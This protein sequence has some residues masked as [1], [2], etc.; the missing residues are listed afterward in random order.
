MLDLRVNNEN[1]F[2][3]MDQNLK[4]ASIKALKFSTA[5]KLFEVFATLI[6]TMVMAR[7]V[8]P[9]DFGII[10]MCS[11]FTGV[12][13]L[14]VDFGT[15]D[16]IIRQKEKKL[17]SGFLSSIFW[18][19]TLIGILFMLV[20]VLV[21]GWIAELYGYEII[22]PIITVLSITVAF[23]AMAS[24]PTAIVIHGLD[25]KRVFFQKLFSLSVSGFVG[26][27]MAL[28]GY[29]VWSLAAYQFVYVISASL[30]IWYLSS[31]MP[32]LLF[33]A[34]HIKDIF[35]FSYYLS[36]SKIMNYFT[37]KGDL[38]LI[39]K[40][41]DAESLGIYSKGYQITVKI[42]K[43]INDVVIKVMYPSMSKIQDDKDMV[44]N[45]YMSVFQVSLSLY[46]IV[47]L[48]GYMYSAEIV[49]LLLGEQWIDVASLVPVFLLL[50][51][52]LGVASVSSHSL[53]AL[54]YTK[55]MFKIVS[56]CSAL[57]ILS[58]II[59]LQ[60]GIKGVAAG[61]LF[62]VVILF[63]LL[64]KGCLNYLPI[65]VVDIFLIFSRNIVLMFFVWFVTTEV[66]LY[67]DIRLGVVRLVVGAFLILSFTMMYFV[68]LNTQELKVM[69]S[70]VKG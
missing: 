15:S 22:E 13:A 18:L 29:G 57:T 69:R 38:F 37:K 59:G 60:W 41:V 67:I 32:S 14:L 35:N 19:N 17:S 7:L 61:Y 8:E 53:K 66:M 20:I 46:S 63:F 11:V 5:S 43:S 33:E 23:S 50:S 48:I 34:K 39:G 44:S 54:G 9:K 42:I 45:V 24:V 30:I 1:V 25:F 40:Y 62:S 49:L 28:N 65:K 6:I 64:L 58:F 52:F 56:F 55:L 2:D 27:A 16:A 51:L 68:L 70:I 36:L 47:F 31:W 4:V 12:S 21:S 3:L 26:I 10:A